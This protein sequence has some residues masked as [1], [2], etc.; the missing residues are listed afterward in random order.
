LTK[1]SESA[2][3]KFDMERAKRYQEIPGTPELEQAH[4]AEV[5]KRMAE[6][7][8]LKRGE[9]VETQIEIEILRRALNEALAA[10]PAAVILPDE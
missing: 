3:R 4:Q 9:A 2:Q 10:A 7:P 6:T 1:L 5:E 8:P